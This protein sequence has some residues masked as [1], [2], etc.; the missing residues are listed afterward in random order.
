MNKHGLYLLGLLG[1]IASA[2]C[3]APTSPDIK[4]YQ[5]TEPPQVTVPQD[6]VSIV[7]HHEKQLPP[8]P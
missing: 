4:L 6:T 8:S 1:L 7:R 3:Y 2:A 5:P